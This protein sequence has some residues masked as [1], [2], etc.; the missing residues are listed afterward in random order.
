ML[1]AGISAK[2]A[3]ASLAVIAQRLAR[4]YPQDDQGQTV[5]VYPEK[6]AR[7]TPSA[8]RS[9]PLA[10]IAFLVLVG[11]VLLVACVN[12]ANFFSLVPRRAKKKWPSAWP[13]ER[14]VRV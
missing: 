11:L 9:V 13:W 8:G 1:K 12:V 7:P 14:G 10:A 3:Q 4:E 6:L 2:S 5:R